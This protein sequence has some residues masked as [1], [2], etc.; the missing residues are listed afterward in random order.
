MKPAALRK[1]AA[2][3]ADHRAHAVDR[4]VRGL[5][6]DLGFPVAV[7]V[8]DH[9]LRVVR[10]GADVAAEVDAPQPRA[11]ELVGVEVDVAC[12]AG[13]RVVFRVRGV[14]FD[15]DLVFAVAIEIADAEF[16]GAV[17]VVLAD[18]RDARRRDLQRHAQVLR[19]GA[20]AASVK[21]ALGACSRPKTIGRARSRRSPE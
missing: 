21:D 20:L 10:A 15:D 12:V 2:R 13:L 9:E 19:T 16:V 17:G 7:E 3:V 5:A 11:V 18:G 1:S 6:R 8:V 14:P 4:S